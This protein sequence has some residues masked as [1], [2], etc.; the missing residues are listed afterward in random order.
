MSEQRLP[1][2][3][4][5]QERPALEHLPT[6]KQRLEFYGGEADWDIKQEYLKNGMIYRYD[7]TWRPILNES[8]HRT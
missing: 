5:G 8:T 3:C 4:I 2:G 7:I 1:C 6:C